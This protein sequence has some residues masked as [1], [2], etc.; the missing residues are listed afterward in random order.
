MYKEKLL[1]MNWLKVKIVAGIGTNFFF[2]LPLFLLLLTWNAK[3]MAG[4]PAVFLGP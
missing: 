2:N 3:M 4:A 1:R